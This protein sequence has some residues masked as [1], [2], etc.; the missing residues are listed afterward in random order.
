MNSGLGGVYLAIVESNKLDE[1]GRIGITISYSDRAGSYPAYIT[2]FMAGNQHGALFLPEEK[3]QV[4]VAFVN[5]VPDAPV[6]IGSLWSQKGKPPESNAD[7][8]NDIKLIKTRAGN[9]IRITDKDGKEQIE[10]AGKEGTT[11]VAL[12][13]AKKTIEIMTVEKVLV[14]AKKVT[15]DGNVDVTGRL[16]VGSSSTTT[17][18]GNRITGS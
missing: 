17:I 18:D 5:G 11:R 10:I 8:K 6:I 13:I 4:L 16:V 2:S 15:L 12:L 7:G 14:R 9:E 1:R 3:D